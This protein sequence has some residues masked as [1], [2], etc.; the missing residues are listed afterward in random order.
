MA[1]PRLAQRIAQLAGEGLLVGLAAVQEP[2]EVAGP[3]A[4]LLVE[5]LGV[6]RLREVVL[7]PL[8]D[9]VVPEERLVRR[10]DALCLAV[11][12][13][14]ALRAGA[15]ATSPSR[16]SRGSGRGSDL[17]YPEAR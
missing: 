9:L 1:K 2:A 8:L 14:D 6:A 13:G 16:R 11:A 3:D 7:L 12:H 15:D 17:E 4:G 5:G 10:L